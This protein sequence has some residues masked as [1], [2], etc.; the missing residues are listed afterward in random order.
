MTENDA[1]VTGADFAYCP[2]HGDLLSEVRS[3]R[4]ANAPKGH[5]FAPLAAE[6]ARADQAEQHITDA[7]AKL[8]QIDI[9]QYEVG[10]ASV[11]EVKRILTTDLTDEQEAMP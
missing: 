7:L 1:P 9:Y 3:W 8:D 10:S 11:S 6:Q 2:T 5:E 4:C